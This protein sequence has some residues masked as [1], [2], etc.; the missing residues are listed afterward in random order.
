MDSQ[1]SNNDTRNT[2]YSHLEQTVNDINKDVG[3]TLIYLE[4]RESFSIVER[5]VLF[6]HGDCLFYLQSGEGNHLK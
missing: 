2:N 3:Y 1:S 4:K 5:Y 6:K